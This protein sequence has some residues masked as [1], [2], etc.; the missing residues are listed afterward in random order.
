MG[1]PVTY[2]LA[3]AEQV[4][5]E[6]TR[7]LALEEETAGV[8][9]VRVASGS[10]VTTF[11]G[12]ALNLVPEDSYLLRERYRL[13]I[14]S[15]G[16]V[17]ALGRAEQDGAVAIFLHTHPGGDPAHSPLDD[18]V[19]EQLRD[20]SMRRTRQPFFV[21]LVLGGTP[22]NPSFAARVY[23][24]D[25]PTWTPLDALRVVG[26]RLRVVSATRKDGQSDAQFDRQVRAFGRLGQELL[27]RLHVGVVGAG[28]TGSAVC[29]QL[30]RLG[31]GRITLIDDDVIEESNLTR[32]HEARRSDLGSPK[33]QLFANAANEIAG[34][35]IDPI[36]SRL[37]S[38]S[39]A[40]ALTSCD[41]VFGCTDDVVGRGILSRLAY[42]YLIPIIDMGFVIDAR[43][44]KIHGLYGR[45][46][47]VLPG[48]PCLLCRG[49]IT[50]QELYYESLSANERV[51]RAREGYAPGL[52]EPAPSVVTYTTLVGSLAVAELL[53]RLFGLD[54]GTPPSELLVRV[55]DRAISRTAGEGQPGHYCTD[56]SVWGLGDQ[57]PML[58]QL[59]GE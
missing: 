2:K 55:H 3:L 45:V 4:W 37:R 6:L 23:T 43:E 29:E 59:W 30:I 56:V 21:S 49:R 51:E 17:P 15:T 16:Y 54:S 24:A 13:S 40:R 28:G 50:A 38:E 33:V 46:T 32:I 34:A 53:N 12:R 26:D 35:L 7:L 11:L 8:L 47:S 1:G 19:D 58:G 44:G 5:T 52:G 18:Q 25:E 48:T 20:L 36:Q 31:I 22:D 57:Q 9:T 41:I 14:A 10:E 42:W 39:V 27:S